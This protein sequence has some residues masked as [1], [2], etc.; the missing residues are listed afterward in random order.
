[1][2][3]AFSLVN[4]MI[5]DICDEDELNTSVRREGIY[6]AVYN[7]W[8]KVAVSIASVASGYLQR[9]TG[10]I[11]GSPTQSESTLFWLRAWEISLPAALCLISVWLMI[12]Y[13]LTEAR[14]YEIKQLLEA[15]RSGPRPPL[16]PPPCSSPTNP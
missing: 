6:F 11:E 3:F 4:S 7:W 15:R 13:P 16:L 12:K 5:A 14:V 9:Y 1:M 10:F 8:W 2:V